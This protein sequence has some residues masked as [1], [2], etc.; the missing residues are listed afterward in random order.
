[1]PTRKRR[2]VDDLSI[3]ELRHLLLEKE[4]NVHDQRL[5]H[6]QKTGRVVQVT[7]DSSKENEN[8]LSIQ[9]TDPYLDVPVKTGKRRGQTRWVDSILFLVEILLTLDEDIADLTRRNIHT[10]LAQLLQQQR[11][12]HMTMVALIENKTNQVGR[13]MFTT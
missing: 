8:E 6:Y 2:P 12:G 4:H 1:M 3:A 13:K 11:L 10:H 9:G 5:A 7:R